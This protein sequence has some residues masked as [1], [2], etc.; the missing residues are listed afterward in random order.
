MP[1]S[2][3]E[4]A[5]QLRNDILS[6]KLPTGSKL[7][8]LRSLAEDLD[9]GRGVA[10]QALDK[11]RAEG[12][13]ASR[14]GAGNYVQG[15]FG[16]NMLVRGDLDADSTAGQDVIAVR[17]DEVPAPEFVAHEL[18][19]PAG[20]PVVLR[21]SQV[22]DAPGARGIQDVYLPAA[23]A[24]GSNLVYHNLGPGGM[25][26]AL[27]DKGLRPDRLTEDVVARKATGPEGD[28]LGL[29]V[30]SVVIE[31][32]R[33]LWSSGVRVAVVREVLDADAFGLSTEIHR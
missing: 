30:G 18:G 27:T 32:T 2:A 4:L 26:A 31:V 9:V 25:A 28:A 13:I 15:G 8:S 17:I 3:D 11:L 29:R 5:A 20:E 23:V 21:M 7:P 22:G 19:V 10:Q 1:L 6:G 14:Q 33:V 24:R 16:R 12:L